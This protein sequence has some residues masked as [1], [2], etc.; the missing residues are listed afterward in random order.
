MQKAKGKTIFNS[1]HA[2]WVFVF[3]YLRRKPLDKV[4]ISIYIYYLYNAY[5]IP[6]FYHLL[7]PSQRD[8][9]N[10]WSNIGFGEEITDV[11]S[12]FSSFNELQFII[13]S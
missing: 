3:I 8:Y 9:S 13:R 6:M 11:E 1:W 7:E 10:K 5:K 2:K 12:N 4:P